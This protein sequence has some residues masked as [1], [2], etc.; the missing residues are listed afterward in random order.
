MAREETLVAER[1]K[2]S[3]ALSSVVAAILLTGLK[4]VVGL[5]TNSL[6]ILSEAAHSGLDLVAALV[7]FFA[8]RAA[9]LPPDREH[10]FGHGKVENFSAL[11]ETL[12]LLATSAWIVYEALTRL[13]AAEPEKVDASLWAFGVMVI[14]IIVDYSRSRALYRV[15]RK[16]RS[17]ALEADA[18]HFS[19]DIWSSSVVIL[20]LFLVRLA[21]WLSPRYAW[22]AQADAVAAMAVAGIVIFVSLQLGKRTVDALLDRAPEGLEERIR[23]AVR[24]VENVQDC[25]QLRMRM[26]GPT[27]F[28]EV[29]V[30]IGADLP[31]ALAHQVAE[32]VQAAVHSACTHCDVAVL[33]EPAE[34]DPED[35]PTQVYALAAAAGLDVHDVRVHELGSGYHVELD[36]ELPGNLELEK[37]HQMATRF[38]ETL[39]SRLHRLNGVGIRLDAAPAIAGAA[40]QVITDR[41][42]ELVQQVRSI[43]AAQET[44]S[45]CQDVQLRLAHGS[46]YA[47]LRCTCPAH[48]SMEEVNRCTLQIQSR[49]H[50]AFPQVTSFLVHVEPEAV[51]SPLQQGG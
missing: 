34:P 13:R 25:S 36:L 22:L 16:H 11:I 32:Q 33:V 48:L 44:V 8:V 19:T 29:T 28:I 6:G 24:Q 18:L 9:D 51:E 30:L 27:N 41:Y 23:S 49:L 37:A 46:L 12:L 31:T 47:S 50:E 15:A 5:L 3:V 38:E 1:E 2:R 42:P 39:R 7:T 26:A 43:V 4:L 20:G 17:Q 40:G 14:S 45:S 35:I 21:G 10:Q